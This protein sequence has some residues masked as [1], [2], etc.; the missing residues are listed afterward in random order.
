MAPVSLIGAIV[1]HCEE[2]PG[3][4]RDGAGL[5]DALRST[6]CGQL[7]LRAI[8]AAVT[9]ALALSTVSWYSERGSES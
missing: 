7:K 3:R 6:A 8:V 5:A 4:T 2:V 1:R 9:S